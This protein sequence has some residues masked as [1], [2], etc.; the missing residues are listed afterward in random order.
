MAQSLERTDFDALLNQEQGLYTVTLSRQA[1]VAVIDNLNKPP[2]PDTPEYLG[3]QIRWCGEALTAVAAAQVTGDYQKGFRVAREAGKIVASE[4]YAGMKQGNL[5]LPKGAEALIRSIG[6]TNDGGALT[7]V[8]IGIETMRYSV[9]ASGFLRSG[10][11]ARLKE[12]GNTEYRNI[13][14]MPVNTSA[15]SLAGT[16]VGG[17]LISEVRVTGQSRLGRIESEHY[18]TAQT[19]NYREAAADISIAAT[20]SEE[21]QPQFTLQ[22]TAQPSTVEA[23][24]VNLLDQRVGYQNIA[25]TVGGLLTVACQSERY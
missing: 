19:I 13:K 24:T 14:R 4:P 8:F 25:R 12:G 15:A 16:M 3:P 22:L 1:T 17:G 2:E 11:V 23:G 9:A 18:I 6:S 20:L 5:A 10:S 21:D 7:A